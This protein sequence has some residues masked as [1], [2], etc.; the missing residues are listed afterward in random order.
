MLS[1]F[2]LQLILRLLNGTKSDD[3]VVVSLLL[4]LNRYHTRFQLLSFKQVNDGWV[5][6]SLIYH[7]NGSKSFVTDDF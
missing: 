2:Y 5:G 7:V 6:F 3:I 1:G 4:T